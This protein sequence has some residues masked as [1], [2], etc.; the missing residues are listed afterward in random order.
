MI[1]DELTRD[2]L[3]GNSARAVGIATA[4]IA[5]VLGLVW[6]IRILA[7]KKLRNAHET[8]SSVDD[9]V[10]DGTDRT[11]LW[12]LFLP[13][14]YLAFRSLRLPA[15]LRTFLLQG[16]AISLIAQVAHWASGLVA[17]WLRRWQRRRRDSDPAS[18]TTLNVFKIAAVSAIWIIAGLAAIDNLGFN[19]GTLIAGLGIGGVAVALAT[20]NILGD[21]FASLSIVI[22]KPFAVGDFIIVGTEMGTVEHIGLKSTQVRSLSGEQLVI[23]NADLLKSRIRNFKRMAERRVVFRFGV[24]Y[25]TSPE[26]LEQIPAM[27]RRA[28]EAQQQTRF[29]RSHFVNFGD[30]SYDFESVYWVTSPEYLMYADIHQAVCLDLIRQFAADGIEFAYPTRTLFVTQNEA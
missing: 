24:I 26:Q 4:A 15:D 16:A 30:S 1:S 6:F 12:L 25:Q 28:V 27:I 14:V 29:D 3:F 19:V 13:V 9:F 23:G 7:R 8:A 5:F 17:F 21:L 2:L 18:V 11:K 20:Q 22:D 10:L